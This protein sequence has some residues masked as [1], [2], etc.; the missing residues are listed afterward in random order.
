MLYDAVYLSIQNL[1]DPLN[2]PV[3]IPALAWSWGVGQSVPPMNQF[4]IN[5]REDVHHVVIV[6]SDEEGQSFTTPKIT[7]QNIIDAAGHA[8]DLMIYTFSPGSYQNSQSWNGMT[9]T[10]WGP[11]CVGG[12]WFQLSNQANL[13]FDSLMQILDETACGG[14]P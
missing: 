7:Q 14:D 3:Q 6:F 12:S 8:D 5:W 2:L 11:I 1:I 10:G 13:M 9:Q 4:N